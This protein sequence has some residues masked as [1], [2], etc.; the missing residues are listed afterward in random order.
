[1][2]AIWI[3]LK[4]VVLGYVIT[5]V[6]TTKQT[7]RYWLHGAADAE[8]QRLIDADEPWIEMSGYAVG[9][10]WL[11]FYLKAQPHYPKYTITAVK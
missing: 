11:C 7:K 2:R 8:L 6:R 3:T 10:G 1:M 9:R 5:E 4:A